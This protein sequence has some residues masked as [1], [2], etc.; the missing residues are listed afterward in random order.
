MTLLSLSL[1]APMNT[2]H[3]GSIALVLALTG[4]GGDATDAATGWELGENPEETSPTPDQNNTSDG[5]NNTSDGDN[6]RPSFS[7]DSSHLVLLWD[8]YIDGVDGEDAGR[9]TIP[10]GEG[11][12]DYEVDWD[13]DGIFDDVNVTGAIS[14]TYETRGEV[15]IRIRGDFPH[16]RGINLEE[17][18]RVKRWW[19]ARS[20]IP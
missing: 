9:I 17:H 16:F 18:D 13:N 2:R 15:R 7:S 20:V 12:F 5:D 3:F 1:E 10:A 6:N 19:C 11:E 4:C 14:H 8:P